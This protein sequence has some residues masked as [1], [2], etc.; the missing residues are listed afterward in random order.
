MTKEKRRIIYIAVWAA[1]L[2][3]LLVA[4]LL[5]FGFED[6]DDIT[7]AIM[8][9]AVPLLVMEADMA[10]FFRFE[11]YGSAFRFAASNFV[12]V[13]AVSFVI[14]SAVILISFGILRPQVKLFVFAAAFALLTAVLNLLQSCFLGLVMRDKK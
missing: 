10:N 11:K 5:N 1:A 6:S 9:P 7:L 4:A 3:A 12:L 2:A 14:E 8:F 13:L